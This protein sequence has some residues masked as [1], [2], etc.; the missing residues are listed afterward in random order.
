MASVGM[1][2]AM[3]DDLRDLV[4]LME[5]ADL[6]QAADRAHSW[7]DGYV[8]AAA[9]DPHRTSRPN[10]VD[11]DGVPVE[12][13]PDPTGDAATRKSETR[14]YR[15]DLNTAALTVKTTLL[16]MKELTRSTRATDED[17]KWAT[18][19]D[20]KIRTGKCE[21][22]GLPLTRGE[23]MTNTDPEWLH[24]IDGRELC[25]SHKRLRFKDKHKTKSTA[26]FIEDHLR[27]R[28]GAA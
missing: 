26:Q 28:H 27:W 8:Q 4:E 7:T 18:P 22:C 15:R 11:E 12:S 9:L 24:I 23:D 6:R 2:K 3:I 14:N 5:K 19:D 17:Q 16:I 20:N 21:C 25:S 13:I 10:Q 1:F